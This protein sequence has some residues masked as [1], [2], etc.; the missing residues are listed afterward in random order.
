[1]TRFIQR[2]VNLK[3]STYWL[4]RFASSLATALL[5]ALFAHPAGDAD[6]DTT[7]ELIA[8]YDATIELFRSLLVAQARPP[9]C[10]R[11]QACTYATQEEKQG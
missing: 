5:D 1:V 8:T 4:V 10:C 6:T 7:R 9:R 11:G 2:V 3:G